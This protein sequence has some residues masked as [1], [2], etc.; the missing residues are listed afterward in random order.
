MQIKE[1]KRQWVSLVHA[2]AKMTKEKGNE[3]RKSEKELSREGTPP[4]TGKPEL[5][6]NH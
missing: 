2:K 4:V 1:D 6:S 3:V 5:A